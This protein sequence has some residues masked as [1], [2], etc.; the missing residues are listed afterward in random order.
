MD[1]RLFQKPSAMEMKDETVTEMK[2]IFPFVKH[3][4]YGSNTKFRSFLQEE[5]LDEEEK[6]LCL[7]LC[8]EWLGGFYNA[9]DK[10]VFWEQVKEEKFLS[11]LKEMQ[12]GFGLPNI[13]EHGFKVKIARYAIQYGFNNSTAQISSRLT[14]QD[15]DIIKL[16]NNLILGNKGHIV[17]LSKKYADNSDGHAIAI[18]CKMNTSGYVQIGLFDPNFGEALF[19]YHLLE[20]QQNLRLMW[21]VD[22]LRDRMEPIVHKT[23][24]EF[25]LD[26]FKY[27]D[28]YS[29]Y[30]TFKYISMSHKSQAS[31]EDDEFRK[32]IADMLCTIEE[33][34]ES[35]NNYC[36]SLTK[37]RF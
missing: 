5:L 1:N 26:M 18:A 33:K 11:K 37:K 21:E 4:D 29:P 22:H 34:A 30:Q 35:D 7:A 19:T 28:S 14:V 24:Y 32:K 25:C 36:K 31:Q 12:K 3:K 15:P 16:I 20:G 6:G 10:N 23:F 17:F 9:T 13:L 8:Y 2:S 27:Y